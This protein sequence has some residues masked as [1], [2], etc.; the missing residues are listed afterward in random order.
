MQSCEMKVKLKGDGDVYN[1]VQEKENEEK[2]QVFK[3]DSF[4]QQHKCKKKALLKCPL[5]PMFSFARG[6]FTVAKCFLISVN[7]P[8]QPFMRGFRE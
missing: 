4:T 7:L 3:Q 6:Q 8:P 5:A 2:T 1:F